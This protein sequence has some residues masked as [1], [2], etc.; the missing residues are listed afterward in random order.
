MIGNEHLIHAL[1]LIC[2]FSPLSC[3]PFT[4][5]FVCVFVSVIVCMCVCECECVYV[6]VVYVSMSYVIYNGQPFSPLS[7]YPR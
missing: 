7:C 2:A 4:C 5:V 6:S 3:S 1:A